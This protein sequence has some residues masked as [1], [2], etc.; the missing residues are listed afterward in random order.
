[1]TRW[2]KARARLAA[3]ALLASGVCVAAGA[4]AEDTP[5]AADEPANR[6]TRRRIELPVK[7]ELKMVREAAK[8]K[9]P[10][11]LGSGINGVFLREAF[12]RSTYTA[13]DTAFSATMAANSLVYANY[14]DL[15]QTLVRSD[16]SQLS[17][18][19]GGGSTGFDGRLLAESAVG[20]RWPLA[21]AHGPLLRLGARGWLQGNDDFYSSLVELPSL[22]AGYHIFKRGLLLEVAARGGVALIGRFR[23]GDAAARRLGESLVWGGHATF[24]IERTLLSA[25]WSR[26][27]VQSGPVDVARVTLCGAAD[28]LLLCGEVQHHAERLDPEVGRGAALEQRALVGGFS[29]GVGQ[30]VE[31]RIA[32]AR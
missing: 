31:P 1:M 23:A 10:L 7:A 13:T 17:A 3:L 21:G 12:T 8:R 25:E 18:H 27:E 2:R 14:M 28:W 9:Q 4:R 30:N 6:T 5:V 22:H 19:M 16:R 32:V 15:G 11:V 24:H 26:I 20:V 29:L